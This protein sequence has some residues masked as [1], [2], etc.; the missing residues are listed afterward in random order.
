M[1]DPVPEMR[2]DCFVCGKEC[3]TIQEYMWHAKYY[4][5]GPGVE[6]WITKENSAAGV[7]CLGKM[8]L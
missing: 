6:P 5:H 1:P 8:Y 7:F 4:T 3:A 2:L